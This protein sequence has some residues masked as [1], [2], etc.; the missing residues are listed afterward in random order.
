MKIAWKR[1]KLQAYWIFS[2]VEPKRKKKSRENKEDETDE[3]SKLRKV[4][5]LLIRVIGLFPTNRLGQKK[6]L[7]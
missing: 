1:F 2:R 5:T 4:D 7:V 3:E 6:L